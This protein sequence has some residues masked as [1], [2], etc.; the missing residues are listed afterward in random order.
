MLNIACNLEG[1]FL[2]SHVF[3]LPHRRFVSALTNP[4]AANQNAYFFAA[5]KKH[6]LRSRGS[7]NQRPCH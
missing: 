7:A 6:A 2:S 1:G 5:K 4:L 3:S